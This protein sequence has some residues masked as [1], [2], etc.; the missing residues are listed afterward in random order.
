M[1]EDTAAKGGAAIA[2]GQ[3]GQG[4]R[5]GA[6]T[7]GTDVKHPVYPAPVNDGV[8]R[9][10]ALDGQVAVVQN[11]QVSADIGV[12]ARCPCQDDG[13]PVSRSG[14]GDDVGASVIIGV[15]DSLAQGTLT[16]VIGIQYDVVFSPGWLRDRQ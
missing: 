8:R 12:F 13:I 10:V 2:D 4:D 11:V 14:K 7:A 1:V 3:T 16:A 9:T 5:I 6:A 15:G